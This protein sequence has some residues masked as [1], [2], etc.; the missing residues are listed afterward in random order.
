MQL[1]ARGGIGYSPFGID[2][3]G[4]DETVDETA[5]RLGTLSGE[6]AMAAPMMRE[7]ARWGFEGRI[8]A[9]VEREDHAE[10]TIDLGGWQAIIKFSATG[11]RTEQANAQPIGKAMVVQLGENE[12]VLVGTYCRF[13]FRPLGANA[14][15]A[16]QYLRVEEGTYE[17]GTFKLLRIRNGDETDWGGPYIGDV[18][19]VLHTT[20]VVR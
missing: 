4:R 3:N 17:N 11:G 5:A 7:L 20:L 13:T 9:V 19:A 18:P 2:D 15:R 8:K 12:F 14:G 1:I 6:Y 16:W 10:Q